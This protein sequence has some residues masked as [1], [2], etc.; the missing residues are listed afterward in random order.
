MRKFHLFT[1]GPTMVPGAVRLAGA[2]DMIHHR[3][4]EFE[5]AIY[6]EV[7]KLLKVV[8]Q[9]EQE[10]LCMMSTGTGAMETAVTNLAARGEKVIVFNGG[11]QRINNR[12]A[13]YIQMRRAY[14]FAEQVLFSAAS[15]CKVI[16][17]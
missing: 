13:R 4:P 15:R 11:M 2:Q 3:T 10:V 8:F 12:I 9:T 17:R 1:P 7:H 14:I 5:Q 6:A 16:G